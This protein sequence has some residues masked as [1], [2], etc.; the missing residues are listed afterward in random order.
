MMSRLFNRPV[1]STYSGIASFSAL[2]LSAL[3]V[4]CGGATTDASGTTAT[5]ASQLET[6]A[7]ADVSAAVG[8]CETGTE[9]PNV[10]CT[11]TAD[12]PAACAQWVNEPFHPCEEGSVTHPHPTKCCDLADGSKCGP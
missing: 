12:A 9:H 1:L 6:V 3:I 11:E 7:L 4:A 10:C 8:T 2:G 5:A